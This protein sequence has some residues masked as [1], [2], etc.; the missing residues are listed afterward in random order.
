VGTAGQRCTSTRRV[1]LHEKIAGAFT[2]HLRAAY[3]Q[4]RIGDPCKRGT[5]MGPLVSEPALDKVLLAVA[6]VQRQGGEI[7]CGGDA[8][9]CAAAVAASSCN[10]P[11]PRVPATL[12]LLCEETFGRCSTSSLFAASTRPSLRTMP[13]S[14]PA[15]VSFS[16]PRRRHLGAAGDVHV[17]MPQSLPAPREALGRL[18][19]EGESA[20]DSPAHGVVRSDGLVEAAN[21][22]EVEQRPERL[23]AEQSN[24][25]GT[26]AM[27]GC[28]KK[29]PLQPRTAARSPP[30]RISPPCR[31]TSATAS[32]TL[33]RAGSLTS[34]P[35]RVP[36]LHGSPMR[37]CA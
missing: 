30:Q 24:V 2:R 29:P 17:A 33:S 7:L 37:T 19:R 32:K 15:P 31:C 10:P 35:I 18:R 5:L 3:A 26:R 34:G 16:P 9:R 28:M 25:A 12:P 27:V 23:L 6:E 8:R 36:R 22:D 1:Y 4:V 21:S 13:A 11:S 14:R 20:L